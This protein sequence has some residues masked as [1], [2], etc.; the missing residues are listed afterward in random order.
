MSHRQQNA[1]EMLYKCRMIFWHYRSNLYVHRIYDIWEPDISH[2]FGGPGAVCEYQDDR[3]RGG[4]HHQGQD[5]EVPGGLSPLH[6]RGCLDEGGGRTR[7]TRHET[8]K[9]RQMDEAHQRFRCG[10]YKRWEV[11]EIRHTLSWLSSGNF[12]TEN[13]VIAN[14]AYYWDVVRLSLRNSYFSVTLPWLSNY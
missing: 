13:F 5:K 7:N 14:I 3:A 4:T 10:Y 6:T 11:K 12:G 1:P 2:P 9:L 8:E